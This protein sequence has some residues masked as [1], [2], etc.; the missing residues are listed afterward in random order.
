MSFVL[1][2]V[3]SAYDRKTRELRALRDESRAIERK[4][5]ERGQEIINEAKARSVEILQ[6]ITLDA[7]KERE[8][9]KSELAKVSSQHL[10]E[11][12]KT[13]Q[14]ISKTIESGVN[15]QTDDFKKVLEMEAVGAEKTLAKR[16]E[17]DYLKA[18]AEL[19]QFKQKKMEEMEGQVKAVVD[20]VSR[21]L[22]AKNLSVDDQT[23][24]ILKALEEARLHAIL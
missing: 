3:L 22:L 8:S 1:A 21:K 4:A 23:E 10:D 11:Y 12:K 19:D 6:Q 14:N 7:E 15:D 18:K 13:I 24:L 17:D 9:I 2:V 16:M 20:K 5:R